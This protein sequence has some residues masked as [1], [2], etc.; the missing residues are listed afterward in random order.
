LNTLL[1]KPTIVVDEPD[2]IPLQVSGG[3]DTD[4]TTLSTNELVTSA[5]SNLSTDEECRYLVRH[6]RKP[7]V[8]FGRPQRK[9]TNV[10]EFTDQQNLFEKAFPCLYPYGMGGI[11]GNQ[12]VTVDF[13]EHIRWS[14]QHWDRRFRRHETFPFLAFGILQRRQALGSARIQ[15]RQKTFEKDAQIMSSLT[16]DKLA[17]ARK[18]EEFGLPISDPA[19]RLLKKHAYSGIGRV[20][21]SDQSRYQL[22]SQIWSTVICKGPPSL[23]IT[24]NPSDIHDPIAQV[25]AGEDID[26]DN[27]VNTV[28]PDKDK[29]AKNIAADPYAAAKFFHFIIRLILEK[30][31]QVK[32][33][34]QKVK[35][36]M[37]ILGRVSSYFGTV[38]SQGRGSLHLHLLVWL[39]HTPTSDELA[40]LFKS[41]EFRGRVQAYIKANLRAYLPGLESLESVKA[42]PVEGDIAYS[43]PPNPNNPNYHEELADFELRL[44][45][46]EQVHTCKLRRCLLPDKDGGYRCKRRAPFRCADEDFVTETGEWGSKRLYAYINGWIPGVLICGRCNND[47]KF[48]TN[49]AD[50][51]NITFYVTSYTAKKQGKNHNISAVITQAFCE[52][53]EKTTSD[54]SENIYEEKRLLVFRLINAINREQEIAAP[55]VISY[56]MGWGDVYR[57]HHYSPIYWSSFVGAL[58]KIF[59]QLKQS[60]T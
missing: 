32:V 33:T 27:F 40:E 17:K 28:G 36:D 49:G 16:V 42:I 59:P 38:E 21:G 2:I 55:M 60:S 30:L 46:N 22:R 11:E 13:S 35:S 19:V 10:E 1:T 26:L 8:D 56:L 4:L 29:R 6:G 24:I 7:V 53:L 51:K 5:L 25:F 58:Y 47:G 9:K 15:M 12:P 57:S 31:F 41:E 45:R 44:A 37:G 50:T 18:E 3:V 52:H 14:L 34:S 20:M 54:M 43:R 23:W 39:C 48:L